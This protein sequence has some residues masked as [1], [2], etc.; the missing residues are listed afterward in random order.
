VQE[1]SSH[2]GPLPRQHTEVAVHQRVHTILPSSRKP[3]ET[4]F[5]VRQCADRLLI[6]RGDAVDGSTNVG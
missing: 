3:A 6:S 2:Y 1:I 4:Q 5:D